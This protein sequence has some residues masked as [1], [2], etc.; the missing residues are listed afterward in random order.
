MDKKRSQI[1]TKSG[2]LFILTNFFLA[3]INFLVGTLSNSLAIISDAIHSLIDSISGFI[4]IISEKIASSKKFLAS[5]DRIEHIT[6][7]IIAIIII[8]VGM[9]III[10]SI[11]KIITPEELNYSLVTIVILLISIILKY[12]LARYLTIMGQ[13]VKSKVLL[14]S[15]AE[16]MNDTWISI[17]VLISVIIHL[18]WQVNVEAYLSIIIAIFILKIGL[19]FIFPRISKHHHHPFENNPDHMSNHHH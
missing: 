9:H 13:K 10:E 14:A 7:I 5:R 19:E 2:R 3:I 12:L 18:I 15:S 16:T 4:I 17:A 11:E 1:I 6:T 8:I